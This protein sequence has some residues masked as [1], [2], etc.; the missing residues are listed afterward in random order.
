MND[1]AQHILFVCI[2]LNGRD[3]SRDVREADAGLVQTGEHR[4]ELRP[5]RHANEFVA[6]ERDDEIPWMIVKRTLDQV[7]HG[8]RLIEDAVVFAAERQR[9]SF[10]RELAENG[11]RRVGAAMIQDVESV[12]KRGVVS[13]NDSMMS[14]SLR[15][16]VT[17]ARRMS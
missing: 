10:L 4:F 8:R 5:I 11:R 12:E 13:A 2:V 16:V 17:A 15:T 3:I 9:Q 14:H 1:A 6:I 7:R